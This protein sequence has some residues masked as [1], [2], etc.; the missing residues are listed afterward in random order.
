MSSLLTCAATRARQE[1]AAQ[2]AQASALET[3]ALRLRAEAS[4]ETLAERHNRL[5]ELDNVRNVASHEGHTGVERQPLGSF[6]M[7]ALLSA[8][9]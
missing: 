7:A 2:R 3:Q 6:V 8:Q 4:E 9:P 5:M 1:A